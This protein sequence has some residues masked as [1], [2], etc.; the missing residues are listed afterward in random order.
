MTINGS[1]AVRIPHNLGA[2]G[3]D[4]ENDLAVCARVTSPRQRCSNMPPLKETYIM[5]GSY[6]CHYGRNHTQ[7]RNDKMRHYARTGNAEAST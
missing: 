3:R 4:L 7:H 6:G 5:H 2:R 1:R